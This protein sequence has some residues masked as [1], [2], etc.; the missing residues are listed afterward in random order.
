M[1]QITN[2]QELIE[3]A[4]DIWNKIKRKSR[5]IKENVL[6]R[7]GSA[8]FV[9]YLTRGYSFS[10]NSASTYATGTIS[11]LRAT[12]VSS[13]IQRLE[14]TLESL[15][16]NGLAK[17]LGITKEGVQRLIW[18]LGDA[19]STRNGSG[20]YSRET[21][22]RVKSALLEERILKQTTILL[23]SQL[24]LMKKELEPTNQHWRVKDY[25]TSGM[26]EPFVNSATV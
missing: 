7:L 24:S 19:R 10:E 16:L 22:S 20:Q 6:L 18:L 21:I 23:D 9:A 3:C 26:V 11:S 1:K 8:R 4:I 25:G 15:N 17:E 12:D 2:E 14:R 5:G 13:A